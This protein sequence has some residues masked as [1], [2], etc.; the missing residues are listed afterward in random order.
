MIQDKMDF[1]M[2]MKRIF[3]FLTLLTIT[4][5]TSNIGQQ[6]DWFYEYGTLE[7]GTPIQM[8]YGSPDMQPGT[9][10]DNLL[11][12]PVHRM[13]VM[14]PLSGD[15]AATGKEIRTS[16]ETAVLQNAPRNLSVAFYDTATNLSD[17]INEVLLDAP[18]IIIGPVFAND[19]RALRNAKPED[20]PVLS[21]TSDA[22]ALGDG[23]MTM[24]LMPT[25]SVEAIVKEMS[26]DGIK[27]FIILAPDTN[28][29]K[30]MAGTAQ[31]ASNIYNVPVSGIFYYKENNSDSI[32]ETTLSA[33]MNGARTAANTRAREILSDILTSE[34]LTAL[35]K[36]SLTLQLE[37]LSKMETLG[38]LPYD[39]VLFLGNGDDTE[40]LA[41]FLRYY[42]VGSREA[43]FYGTAVWE[44]SDIINDFT[45]VGAKYAVLPDTSPEFTNLYERISGNEPGRLAG[46]G[47][48]AANM[49]MGMIYSTKSD[50]AYLLDPSG[51]AGVEGLYRLK[52][53]GE[54]ERALRIVQ[55]NGTGEPKVIKESATNFLTPIYNIEQYKTKSAYAMDLE[56][57]GI[58]PNDYINIP[59]R[60]SNKYKSKTYGAHITYNNQTTPIQES[61]SVI[62][63][64]EDDSDA[65]ITSP[66]FQPITLESINRTYIDSVEI[67]E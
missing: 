55:L 8:Q 45:M 44:G 54:N 5:C 30:L 29:G 53:T 20:L 25:N 51:Y 37:R 34:R 6:S 50:A 16:I 2:Y 66:E 23:V 10:S 9:P 31:S 46:F 38:K 3:A 49:A 60:L 63:L 22:T 41:S 27:S 26:S 13:A 56:T 32:K 39:A 11:G 4:G 28:S 15:A 35:E 19:V 42:G 24:A 18:E 12:A 65:V 48:D 17:T 36:S 57:P 40:S 64:P 62:I 61:Q 52:P 1:S 58:N 43:K 59:Q 14:L 21:F 33:S 47:Y 67:E 7:T